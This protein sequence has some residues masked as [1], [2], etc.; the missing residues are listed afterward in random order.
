[1]SE[2]MWEHRGV[3]EGASV[4]LCVYMLQYLVTAAILDQI[5]WVSGTHQHL[6]MMMYTAL[7]QFFGEGWV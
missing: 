1:M 2:Y 3:S 7:G 6:D 4:C 5:C